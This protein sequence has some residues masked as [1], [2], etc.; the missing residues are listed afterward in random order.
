MGIIAATFI[1]F[2]TGV[3]RLSN[4]FLISRIVGVWVEF[5]RNVPVLLQIIFWWLI[6]VALPKWRESISIGDTIFLNNRGARLPSPIWEDGSAIVLTTV[7]VG[8][9]ATVAIRESDSLKTLTGNVCHFVVRRQFAIHKREIRVDEIQD[10]QITANDFLDEIKHFVIH[11]PL[12]RFGKLR[13]ALRADVEM[14]GD[15][16][17]LEPVPGELRRQGGSLAVRKHSPYL[18]FQ[19]LRIVQP[20]LD[21]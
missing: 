3:L 8:I 13:K 1:G 15:L 2:V 6:M 10:A 14:V 17:E 5:T 9:A 11:R 19:H 18:S 21:G 20:L 4:N 16:V 12:Q 7:L